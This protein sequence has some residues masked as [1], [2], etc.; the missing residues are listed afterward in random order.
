MTEQVTI[1]FVAL[2]NMSSLINGVRSANA[3]IAGLNK[4]LAGLGTQGAAQ[5][6]SINAEFART[7]TM[8][9]Q[10]TQSMV[11]MEHQTAR[12][13]RALQDGK[14]SIAEY[15]RTAIE[16]YRGIGQAQALAERQ[17]RYQ[18]SIVQSLGRD[19][20]GRMRAQIFT[21]TGIDKYTD[22]LKIAQARQQIFNKALWDGGTAV[23][24]L[25]KN[26]QWAGRQL[27]VGLTLPLVAF[28]AVAASTFKKVDE[29]L[30]RIV[31]V[32]G[33]G[34]SGMTKEASDSLRAQATGLATELA[35]SMGQ[36]MEDTLGLMADIAATGKEGIELMNA[37]REASRLAVL[38]EVDRQQ[39]M[40]ATVALQ[41]TWKMSTDEL[42]ESINFLNAV[43]NQT[44]TSLE[45]LTGAIPRAGAVVAGLG[46]S[47]KDLSLYM[48][49]MREG[50]IE[51][52][53]AANAIKSG[54]SAIIAPSKAVQET[55]KEMGIDIKNIVDRNAGEL[56]PT[57]ME[58]GKELEKLSSLDRQRAISQL[59]GRFQF[60]RWSALFQNLGKEGSQTIEVL[61]LMSQS[62]GDLA[63]TAARE[64]GTVTES[65]S[66]QFKR[67]VEGLKASLL[68]VGEAMLNVFTPII[69]G[70][71]GLLNA[72][73][74]LPEPIK[75]VLGF[76]G[77]IVALAGP[78]IMISG[79][80]LNA[81]GYGLKF[82][83]TLKNLFTFL[84]TGERVQAFRLMT[85][86]AVMTNV[87][88]E[89]VEDAVY[90]QK[91][92]LDVLGGSVAKLVDQYQE[93][94]MATSAVDQ[95]QEEAAAS[96]TR[97]ARANQAAANMSPTG[98]KE[99]KIETPGMWYGHSG[100]NSEGKDWV[101]PEWQRHPADATY[102]FGQ[103]L[104]YN[105]PSPVEQQAQRARF[106]G[107]LAYE[108]GFS[109]TGGWQNNAPRVRE[110]TGGTVSRLTAGQKELLAKN[111]YLT[112]KESTSL[113]QDQMGA[114]L[115]AD[116]STQ[117]EINEIREMI[118]QDF[119][120]Y[121]GV[122]QRTT[123]ILEKL[124]NGE[125][126]EQEL[127]NEFLRLNTQNARE[128]A[129]SGWSAGR[130]YGRLG[131]AVLWGQESNGAVTDW[132]GGGLVGTAG[133][134]G[135]A[136]HIVPNN[137]IKELILKLENGIIASEKELLDM[138]VALSHETE[139]ISALRVATDKVKKELLDGGMTQK[140]YDSTMNQLVT[141]AK[142]EIA[143]MRI[144]QQG[145]S[146]YIVMLDSNNKILSARN[147]KGGQVMT[148]ETV[149]MKKLQEQVIAKD[150]EIVAT[151]RETLE[152][153]DTA[154][155]T[156]EAG[157][158]QKQV[159]VAGRRLAGAETKTAG[160]VETVAPTQ[161][162]AATKRGMSGLGKMGIGL[163][164]A[165]MGSMAYM[166]P[167][168]G[169][170]SVDNAKGILGGAGMG[171]SMG[172]MFGAPGALVGAIVG[173]LIPAVGML[174]DALSS[175]SDRIEG[176]FQVGGIASSTFG[177][178]V[179]T[180]GQLGT[181]GVGATEEQ[182]SKY[183]QLVSDFNAAKTGEDS[184][185]KEF[186]TS[187]ADS[188]NI[189]EIAGFVRDRVSQLVIAGMG[190]EDIRMYVG[191][192]LE[193][194]GQGEYA[195]KIKL[196]ID[197]FEIDKTNGKNVLQDLIND[198][199]RQQKDLDVPVEF[200]AK[201]K[202]LAEKLGKET[203]D[204][205]AEMGR[206]LNPI[207][208]ADMAGLSP[209]QQNE[210]SAQFNEIQGMYNDL[211][212]GQ[213]E[214]L[215]NGRIT[216][217]QFVK[218]IET[219]ANAAS[220]MPIDEFFELSKTL[221]TSAVAASD[222]IAIVS[223]MPGVTEE[224][225]AALESLNAVG[226]STEE[227]LKAI[228]L[229]SSGVVEGGW[230]ALPSLDRYQLDALYQES[231]TGSSLSDALVKGLTA[232][233]QRAADSAA[234]ASSEAQLADIDALRDR[235]QAQEEAMQKALEATREKWA[236]RLEAIKDSYS[237]QIDAIK[238]A[239]AEQQKAFDREK[240]RIEQMNGLRNNEIDMQKAM[241]EGDLYTAMKLASDREAMQKS[242]AI[243][244]R[245][246]DAQDVTESKIESLE[247][248]RDRK[249][250]AAEDA[251]DAEIKAAED[252]LEAKKKA[253]EQAV[254][255]AQQANDAIKEQADATSTHTGKK[256]AELIEFVKKTLD[257]NKGNLAGA[258]TQIEA[259]AERLGIDVTPII[260]D[261]LTK[262]FGKFGQIMYDNIKAGINNTP[263]D[264]LT[265]YANAKAEGRDTTAITNQIDAYYAKVA[266]STT[267]YPSATNAGTHYGT[268][269]VAGRAFG[270]YISGPGTATSDSI[271]ARLSNGE[272]VIRQSAVQ[273]YGVGTLDAINNG[274]AQ[275]AS[276]GYVSKIAGN[277]MSNVLPGI[278]A[279]AVANRV[280]NEQAAAAASSSGSTYG[281]YTP[282]PIDGDMTPTKW[283]TLFLEAI[284]APVTSTT[285]QGMLRWIA[286]EG[287]HWANAAWFNPLNTTKVL[288]GSY[289]MNHNPNGNGGTPV[290]AYTDWEQGLYANV[291]TIGLGG[292]GY[293]KIIAALR[294]QNLDAFV[295]AVNA[296][297][298]GT[299]NS[300]AAGGLVGRNGGRLTDSPILALKK[301]PPT[302]VTTR[303]RAP[304]PTDVAPDANPSVADI[305]GS[306][307]LAAKK[308]AD[309]A[310]GF[311]YKVDYSGP[312]GFGAI[313]SRTSSS[314]DSAAKPTD[315]ST[316]KFRNGRGGWGC[317]EFTWRMA[318]MAKKRSSYG[319]S[320]AQM[321]WGRAV[322]RGDAQ[323]GDYIIYDASSRNG[324]GADHVAIYLGND[325]IVEAANSR[326]GT[327]RRRGGVF[328]N[329]I[330]IRRLF[331][332]GGLVTIP[333]LSV[334]GSINYDNTIAN[335]HKGE[336][337][338]TEP[339][340]KKLMDGIE[341]LAGGNDVNYNISIN[342][343]KAN[344]TPAEVEDAVFR[345]LS[346]REAK[347]GRSRS[348]VR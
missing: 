77:G 263:W 296:S 284:G 238:K 346:R 129:S 289:P 233:Q 24:N 169:N 280:T 118:L 54:L 294:A 176:L 125:V 301:T 133:T 153:N 155:K 117:T 205:L 279:R 102:S 18:N 340:S 235:L 339:L 138:A 300:F 4:N 61:N 50:G 164:L 252:A 286:A 167:D 212:D 251:R 277:M 110:V 40:T 21:P 74:Q 147:V 341:G 214:A 41:T 107:M 64:L 330:S 329:A 35:K 154:N 184:A 49:A 335:L 9:G 325:E 39:A 347:M 191:A 188:A 7:M 20:S 26:T 194:A 208:W 319:Y 256:Y 89:K 220:T 87:A 119:K 336:T 60:S 236:D 187:I 165:T 93:L 218:G 310:S 343:D 69:N 316:W 334:G 247:N 38:G 193:S 291:Y 161:G 241:A 209:D 115:K 109:E 17:V 266:S 309:Y 132:L 190:E 287:G 244:N 302:P 333:G 16:A 285:L 342:I 55:L 231:E 323:A 315:P 273:R 254:K 114:L 298:W 255:S 36:P 145:E 27:M 269:P 332:Q 192:A 5:L 180:F 186:L 173:G 288:P 179:T 141:A 177:A 162:A 197:S 221:D 104:G 259:E 308:F 242:Y 258:I 136:E 71:T 170:T 97:Q 8:S 328:N 211:S 200:I 265:E 44:S 159:A 134:P 6:A 321:G 182:K 52:S 75:N 42:A 248:E 290:Q 204:V 30:T 271:P 160:V 53:Q 239:D 270:G 274:V 51:A 98:L 253:N 84:K 23:T 331:N 183:E 267:P 94:F 203:A 225:T 171:A 272:Y 230:A 43:E 304:V 13:G 83:A 314:A 175:S 124:Q 178:R 88:I 79:V 65:A 56:T 158:S 58:L 139:S 185:D 146:R 226:W 234:A 283:A 172:M 150:A 106:I 46:G 72:F 163:G 123:D 34:L 14:L 10:F 122:T 112:S 293:D 206:G 157:E 345:A 344:A 228:K 135:E 70:I 96:A 276:G 292:H 81:V 101:G 237:K 99:R 202:S 15:R 311:A 307:P 227:M 11:A 166:I 142:G 322:A 168:T 229:I 128:R 33:S 217:E 219:I 348:I 3:Q 116:L 59:F 90:S 85:E 19:A 148:G 278:I 281:G 174:T 156:N 111:K 149:L 303:V 140:R 2:S 127:Y 12:F 37:T 260:V 63:S 297:G 68:P 144:V 1:E 317:S 126:T 207:N 131:N 243:T 82:L 47:V 337:V 28:G 189:D 245:R 31:K 25:G 80:L 232:R 275:F 198:G 305:T 86:D 326:V 306:G 143:S 120:Q 257:E 295:A 240:R 262:T 261:T 196:R 213:K 91:A 92:A 282:R 224:Q 199:V 105:A 45:D 299:I 195:E 320:G 246:E 66:G 181:L 318:Q 222:F 67:A 32:Y 29:Q 327:I 152:S 108:Q 62:A 312:R 338:L 113:S 73:N 268:D 210:L 250:K 103:L 78:V 223:E 201:A 57:I 95:A 76:I 215:A 216:S 121:F 324:D 249:I 22:A 264:L 137:L 130:P 100:R 48:T 151:K 313:N